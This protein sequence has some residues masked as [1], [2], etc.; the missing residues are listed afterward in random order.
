M[1]EASVNWDDT[2]S[3][4]DTARAGM[5]HNRRANRGALHLANTERWENWVET[6]ETSTMRK[7]MC[8]EDEDACRLREVSPWTGLLTT[9]QRQAII[10]WDREH[11]AS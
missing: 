8:A 7:R 1:L 9:T 10:D 11:D 2:L 5:R 4:L 3:W 6:E